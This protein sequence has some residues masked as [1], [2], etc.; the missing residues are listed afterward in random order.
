MET[1]RGSGEKHEP[2]AEKPGIQE[3]LASF[4]S[5]GHAK[6]HGT[7]RGVGGWDV[8]HLASRSRWGCG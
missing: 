2:G 3:N 8:S 1:Q 5:P 7:D 6:M 4:T